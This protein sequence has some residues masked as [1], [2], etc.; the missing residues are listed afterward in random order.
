MEKPITLQEFA[1]QHRENIDLIKETVKIIQDNFVYGRQHTC[2]VCDKEL[3]KDEIGSMSAMDF[4]YTCMTHRYYA[5]YFIL[6][7]IRQDIMNL[8]PVENS[9]LKMPE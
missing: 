8:P 1:D 6:D 9:Y 2:A 3:S 7:K 4:H 5:R